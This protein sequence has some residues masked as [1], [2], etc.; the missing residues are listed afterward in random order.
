LEIPALTD[1]PFHF[2]RIQRLEAIG[3]IR[4]NADFR[5]FALKNDEIDLF[6]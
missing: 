1:W 5:R 4:N 2:P 3:P 6:D